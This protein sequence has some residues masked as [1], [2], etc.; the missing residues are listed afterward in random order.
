ML[1]TTT[2]LPTGM[3]PYEILSD[4]LLRAGTFLLFV[5]W[6]LGSAWLIGVFTKDVYSRWGRWQ[7]YP[8]PD[9]R[10]MKHLVALLAL[11]GVW[12]LFLWITVVWFTV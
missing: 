11:L 2:P 6:L 12:A 8:V 10:A 9:K 4:V 7:T 1:N 3:A 5:A